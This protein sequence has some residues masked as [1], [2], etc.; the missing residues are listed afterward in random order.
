MGVAEPCSFGLLEPCL[1]ARAHAGLAQFGSHK[2][3]GRIKRGLDD[4]DIERLFLRRFCHRPGDADG[5]GCGERQ[6]DKTNPGAFAGNGAAIG[7]QIEAL[8]VPIC[9]E[10]CFPDVP[11][12]GR[13][14]PEGQG[15]SAGASAHP[16]RWPAPSW[17]SGRVFSATAAGWPS[18]QSAA[19]PARAPIPRA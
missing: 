6:I 12:S 10:R 18:R 13:R 2:H 16:P 1:A 17:S 8:A 5:L 14:Q 15:G 7:I 9:G 19:R 3:H 4:P 11:G